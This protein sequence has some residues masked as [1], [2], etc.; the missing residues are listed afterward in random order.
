MQNVLYY[1][2]PILIWGSTWFAIKFQLGMVPPQLSVAY[3]SL[4]ASV[5]LFVFLNSTGKCNSG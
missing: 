2:I 4:L 5:L 3:R 1:L